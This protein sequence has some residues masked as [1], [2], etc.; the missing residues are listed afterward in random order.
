MLE[1]HVSE[2]APNAGLQ[3]SERRKLLSVKN[4]GKIFNEDVEALRTVSLT[5]N[6]GD[7]ISLLGPSGCGKSTVLRMIA[8]LLEPTSGQ[9]VWHVDHDS[10]DIGVVF[11]EPTLMPWATVEKNVWLPFRLMDQSFDSVAAKNSG[12]TEPRRIGWFRT[13]LSQRIVRRHEDARIH[14]SGLGNRS[15]G[16]F[17]GRTFCGA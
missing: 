8:G 12:G 3:S 17:D 10:G 7:F 6:S 5:V 9:I 13:E 2:L 4:V 1:N 16:Y 11:Q 14:R 15:E